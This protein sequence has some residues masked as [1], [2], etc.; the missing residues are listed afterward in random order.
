[1]EVIGTEGALYINCGEAGLEIQDGTGNHMP[2]TVYWPSVF[3]Q[4]IGA[5]RAEFRY[6]ADCVSAGRRPD[7]ITPDE[8]RDAVALLEAAGE[9]SRT[10]QI[11][12]F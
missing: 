12:T 10:G 9:S 6:F 2:D 4:R 3:G 8:S 1:M 11:V 5:L 7:R